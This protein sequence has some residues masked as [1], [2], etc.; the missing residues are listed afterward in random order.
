MGSNQSTSGIGN[1]LY[2]GEL[3]KTEIGVGI[4]TIIGILAIAYGIYDIVRRKQKTA[5]TQGTIKSANCTTTQSG[6]TTVT[7]CKLTITYTVNG[8]EMTGNTETS[9]GTY[10]NGQKVTIEYDPAN[11]SNFQIQG[12]NKNWIGGIIIGIAIAVMAL[13]WI[14]LYFVRKSKT[15]GQLLAVRDIAHEL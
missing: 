3:I 11:P 9:F 1:V 10:N 6:K 12:W 5:T 8:K 2:T 13:S 7:Q 4:I 14:N 15:Y